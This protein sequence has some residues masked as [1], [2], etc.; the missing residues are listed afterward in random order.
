MLYIQIPKARS[1]RR[2]YIENLHRDEPVID[3]TIQNIPSDDSSEAT[4]SLE[5]FDVLSDSDEKLFLDY[6]EEDVLMGRTEDPTHSPERQA[7]SEVE[8]YFEI[9]IKELQEE[10]T[11][12]KEKN[13]MEKEKRKSKVK[14]GFMRI[15][16]SKETKK[17]RFYTGLTYEQFLVL[18]QFLGLPTENTLQTWLSQSRTD[19]NVVRQGDKRKS[20]SLENQLFLTLVRLRSGLLVQDLSY[21]FGVSVSQVSKIVTT[22]V[23]LIYVQFKKIDIFPTA[24]ATR[25]KGLPK[26]FRKFKNIRT[27]I[28]GFEIGMQRS[29]DYRQQGNTY[30]S[31]K[32]R[33][34]VKF[35]VGIVPTG[36][37]CFLSDGFEGCIS[38]KEIVRKSGLLE[39]LHKQDLILA[40]R[41]FNIADLCNKIGC[42]VLIPPF[43][44]GRARLTNHEVRETRDIAAAR[45]HVERFIGRMKEFRIL[46]KTVTKTMLPMLSQIVFVIAMMVN[47]Q[48]PLLE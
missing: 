33:N 8:K 31:Y 20:L 6:N 3:A 48:S 30:S 17:F 41:G 4:E 11:L 18:W 47:F 23:Q 29:N 40:D 22:W 42:S 12:L 46:Q 45:I 13:R 21:R 37:C 43:L 19:S 35:L 1:S 15:E 2:R 34:T 38:D 14:N 26:A 44:K 27:I 10:I 7:D 28:D 24:E 39:L 32:S 25:K 9:K 5:E 16:S 36:G